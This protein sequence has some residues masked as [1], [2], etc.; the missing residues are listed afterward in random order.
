M[1]D[2]ICGAC[3][4]ITGTHECVDE[5][6]NCSC[7]RSDCQVGKVLTGIARRLQKIKKR[8]RW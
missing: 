5:Q 1:W 6:G 7:A 4:E 3:R 8:R 2:K